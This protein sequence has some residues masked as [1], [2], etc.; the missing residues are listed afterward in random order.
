V[1]SNA[2]DDSLEK[3]KVLH[4]ASGGDPTPPLSC[5]HC[6]REESTRDWTPGHSDEHC[7]CAV[8]VQPNGLLVEEGR[9]WTP[10]PLVGLAVR[11]RRRT[12]RMKHS[13]CF[14]HANH[15]IHTRMKVK[16]LEGRTPR[17]RG[18]AAGRHNALK[19]RGPAPPCPASL[20]GH[21][22]AQRHEGAASGS[23]AVHSGRSHSSSIPVILSLLS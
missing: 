13:T 5:H 19:A 12:A 17:P 22:L 11:E 1:R 16:T 15:A 21:W 20:P 7:G 2:H 23:P 8:L 18:N 9:S 3:R 14:E 4:L 10:G 6:S